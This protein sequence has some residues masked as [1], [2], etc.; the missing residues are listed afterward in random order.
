MGTVMARL[1]VTM[2]VLSIAAT[3]S[4]APIPK[5]LGELNDLSPEV[6]T[7]HRADMAA[8]DDAKDI[9]RMANMMDAPL[10]QDGRTSP[11]YEAVDSARA[12]FDHY[13]RPVQ[14]EEQKVE[15][16]LGKKEVKGD[17]RISALRNA[18]HDVKHDLLLSHREEVSLDHYEQ[19]ETWD[20]RHQEEV[21]ALNAVHRP[22][23]NG[24]LRKEWHDLNHNDAAIHNEITRTRKGITEIKSDLVNAATEIKQAVAKDEKALM[25]EMQSH[26]DHQMDHDAQRH[27]AFTAKDRAVPTVVHGN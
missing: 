17:E 18:M 14:K 19:R 2:V 4:A 20:G 6:K 12:R 10:Q 23:G 1:R 9:M 5:M 25:F 16:Y 21:Q 8:L 11:G 22:S 13:V 27:N 24:P 15:K 7:V 26:N 3:I